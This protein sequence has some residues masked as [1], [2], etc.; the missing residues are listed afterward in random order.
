MT[1]KNINEFIDYSLEEDHQEEVPR[2]AIRIAGIL[3]VDPLLLERI[4]TYLQ[5]D[6]S[7][8]GKKIQ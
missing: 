3:G 1:L 5:E 2:E 6:Y 8:L 7:S 4:E